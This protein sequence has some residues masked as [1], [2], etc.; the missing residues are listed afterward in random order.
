[1]WTR[2]TA[3]IAPITM[4]ILLVSSMT[5]AGAE[6][7]FSVSPGEFTVRDAPPMGKPWSIE[8]ELVVWNRDNVGRVVT[9]TTEV[10]FEDLITPGYEPIPNEN[11]VYP[12]PSSSFLI[13]ENS[14]HL[15]Q[16]SLNIPRWENLTGQ[17][18]EVWIG[19]ERQP[20]PGEIGV[21]RPTV[22]MKIETTE[23]L[24]PIS[25]LPLPV[26]VIVAVG[27]GAV[28]VAL[29]LWIWSKRRP[30]KGWELRGSSSTSSKDVPTDNI[31]LG[32][33]IL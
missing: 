18:W 3:F 33:M 21:L 22:R 28:V 15:V 25:E 23:E 13:E 2:R 14:Y 12:L 19:V 20:F 30:R 24:P 10:P 6:P 26:Y 31:S 29:G 7:P 1:M 4:L 16:I 11:W 8:T 9:V 5:L 17:K 27:A 32:I